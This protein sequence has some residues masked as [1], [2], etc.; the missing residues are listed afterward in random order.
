[1]M[2][3]GKYLYGLE[4]KINDRLSDDNNKPLN[5]EISLRDFS[6]SEGTPQLTWNYLAI[7]GILLFFAIA[8]VVFGNYRIWNEAG[9]Q[10]LLVINGIE[11]FVFVVAFAILVYLGMRFR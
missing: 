9:S 8:S 3:A 5:W 6:K 10:F 7:L 2:R 11:V 4:K 1:M